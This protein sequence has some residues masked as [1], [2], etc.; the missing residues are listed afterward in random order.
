M[1]LEAL[2]Y[3]IASVYRFKKKETTKYTN[4]A[5]KYLEGCKPRPS[6]KPNKLSERY[7]DLAQRALREGKLS[8]MQFRKYMGISYKE[9]QGYLTEN[10]DFKD[11]KISISAA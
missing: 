9:A 1:S 3:R 5:K 7:C 10:K 4:A 8:L 11:E 6:Y 2:I